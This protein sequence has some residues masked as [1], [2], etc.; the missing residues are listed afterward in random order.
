MVNKVLANKGRK[1]RS[2]EGR[3]GSLNGKGT[4][5]GRQRGNMVNKEKLLG[6]LG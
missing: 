3:G 5:Y 4:K 1:N 2:R 6:D